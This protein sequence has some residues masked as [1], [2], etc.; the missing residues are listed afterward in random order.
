MQLHVLVIGNRV[1]SGKTKAEEEWEI[2]TL[3]MLP[4]A[5]NCQ[6]REARNN[7]Q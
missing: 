1:G 6:S 4:V 7:C 3:R 5:W 2:I